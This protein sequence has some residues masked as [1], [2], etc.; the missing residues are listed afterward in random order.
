MVPR[1]D[2]KTKALLIFNTKG[3][4]LETGKILVPE[5]LAETLW[6]LE[7]VRQGF[8]SKSDADAQEALRWVLTRQ[9]L[10][11]SYLDGG[12]MPTGLDL[13]HGVHLLT[14]ERMR[15]DAGTRHIL[16]EEALRT[17]I[18][19]KLGSS[20]AAKQ[21][22]RGFNNLLEAGA[23]GGSWCCYM[24]TTAFL[25]TLAV[26][27]PKKWDRI[28][29]EGLSKIKKARTPDGRWHGF[30]F[31]YTLLTL[32]EIDTPSAKAE[33]RHAGK[34]AERLLKRYSKHDR[35]SRFRRLGLEAALKTVFVKRC[36]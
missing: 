17:V 6:R 10:Q 28:L 14:G 3:S 25:R 18:V 15:S 2:K 12:F 34:V 7:E 27:K 26:A 19:W 8:R 22:L 33:L 4:C 32:S 30:P 24:C 29:E 35:V 31:Y 5:S 9:G 23:K 13:S 36:H 20:S 16:D 1:L 21:A 11:G